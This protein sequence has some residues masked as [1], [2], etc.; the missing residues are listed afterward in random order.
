MGWP[1][2]KQVA[3]AALFISQ[4]M[5]AHIGLWAE[6]GGR[7]GPDFEQRGHRPLPPPLLSRLCQGWSCSARK[8]APLFPEGSNVVR[9]QSR[10][11]V[12]PSGELKYTISATWRTRREHRQILT[13]VKRSRRPPRGCEMRR[14]SNSVFGRFLST[15]QHTVSSL[16]LP[17]PNGFFKI[18][19]T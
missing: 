12:L 11:S 18:L 10:R 4:Q 15:T 5:N 6:G 8:S 7:W 2:L 1:V 19:F 9:R 13:P 16:Q 17:P 3:A 14:S